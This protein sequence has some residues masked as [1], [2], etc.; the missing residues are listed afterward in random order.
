MRRSDSGIG[1]FTE[2]SAVYRALLIPMDLR[3]RVQ[4]NLCVAH[5]DFSN[6]ES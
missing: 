5:I 4:F 3:I 6:S 2:H 1:Q